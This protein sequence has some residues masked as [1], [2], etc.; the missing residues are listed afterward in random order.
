MIVS[1][2]NAMIVKQ[3]VEYAFGVRAGTGCQR[4][5][6]FTLDYFRHL[7]RSGSVHIQ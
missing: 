6:E 7:H 1:V 5:V 3:A 2:V 4:P